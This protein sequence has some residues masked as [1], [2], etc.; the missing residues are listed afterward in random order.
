M[1]DGAVFYRSFYEAIKDLPAD[2]F[3]ACVSA[4]MDYALDEKEPETNGIE[5]TVYLMAK[6]QIDANNKRYQNG[7]KGGRPKTKAEPNNNQIKTEPKPNQEYQK[8]K[9]KEKDKKKD[10]EKDKEKSSYEDKKKVSAETI[11]EP[12]TQFEEF[13]AH[14]PNSGSQPVLAKRRTEHA[15]ASASL[16]GFSEAD[17][18]AAAKNYAEAVHIEERDTRYIKKPENFLSDGTYKDYLPDVYVKPEA[19]RKKPTAADRYNSGIMQRNID[20][21]ALERELLGKGG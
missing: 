20:L 16:C 8:T 18:I 11:P 4:I 19:I 5:K 15:Y 1:R 12:L 17:L 2:Q 13:W 10:K 21:D 9:D 14:Y 3:K 6:P 7:T